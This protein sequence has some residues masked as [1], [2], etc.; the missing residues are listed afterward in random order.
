[1][2]TPDGPGI[3]LRVLRALSPEVAARWLTWVA[4]PVLV[5]GRKANRDEE[6]CT[7]FRAAGGSIVCWSW[8]DA[9]DQA[10]RRLEE[11]FAFAARV[12]AVSFILNGEKGW[13]KH[14]A[15]E[16]ASRA[17]ALA[18]AYDMSLGLVSYSIPR[19]IRDFPWA[20]FAKYVDY[21]MPEIYD[22]R[23][24]YDPRY[25]RQA[26]EGY[27][28]A[29]FREVVPACALYVRRDG[30]G[31]RWRTDPEIA[32]HLSLFPD[33]RSVCAWTIGTRRQIP[34]AALSA[35]ALSVEASIP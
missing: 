18:Y 20:D 1:M 21:G 2:T 7:R 14:S 30:G 15:E 4:V 17:R 16:Y 25:P 10:P 27:R 24:A 12:G 11:A 6:W 5:R 22:R 23:G 19:S 3:F 9:P 26:M 32:R 8:F 35:L 28:T 31:W 29:G 34:E 33:L 13:R